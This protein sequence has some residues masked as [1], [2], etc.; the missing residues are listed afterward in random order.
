MKNVSKLLVLVLCL[1]VIMASFASATDTKTYTLDEL[2]I[3]VSIP[4]ELAVFTRNIP[5]DDPNLAVFGAD[6]QSMEEYYHSNNIYLD[7]ISMDTSSELIITMTA[8]GS[9]QEAFHFNLIE[10]R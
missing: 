4:T 7:A 1:T 6:K 9:S 10:D 8:D 3:E 2:Y 5:A